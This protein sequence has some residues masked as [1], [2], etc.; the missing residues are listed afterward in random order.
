MKPAKKGHVDSN[1]S[2]FLPRTMEARIAVLSVR[3][4]VLLNDKLRLPLELKCVTGSS[5]AT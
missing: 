5:R 2:T 3:L 1:D 4:G